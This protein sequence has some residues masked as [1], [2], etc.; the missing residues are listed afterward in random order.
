MTAT[1]ETSTEGRLSAAS[2]LLVAAIAYSCFDQ[3]A[4]FASQFAVLVVLLGGAG[5]A[6]AL[7]PTRLDRVPRGVLL[8]FL[9]LAVATLAS[10]SRAGDLAGALPTLALI[11]GMVVAFAVAVSEPSEG[12]ETLALG[13]VLC[14]MIAAGTAWIGVA[15]HHEP[16]G[17]GVGGI[18][19]GASGLTY[20][21]ATGAL[22]AMGL[23]LAL[24]LLTVRP[25]L[26]V[27]AGCYLLAVGLLTTMSRAGA[28]A[29][30]VGLV[31]L[32]VKLGWGLLGRRLVAL[33]PGVLVAGAA[34]APG[35]AV[36]SATR[37]ELT[38]PGL[39]AGLGLSLVLISRPTLA[40]AVAVVALVVG[41][42]AL[43]DALD[44]ADNEQLSRRFSVG[45]P[46]RYDEW[47]AARGE[48][49]AS[50]LLGQGPGQ[51]EF[52]W[53]DDG[54]EQ[55][56]ARFAHN[57]YL[58]LLATHGL[59]GLAALAVLVVAVVRAGRARA[60]PPDWPRIGASA[61]LVVFVVHS[62]FDFLWHVP[63]LPVVAAVLL[64]V[65]LSPTGCDGRGVGERI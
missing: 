34:L 17:L 22:L 6:L 38:W 19:R 8:G 20:A 35:I 9:A 23:M 61:G 7:E 15:L 21:N 51:A 59:V 2:W 26:A 32:G 29:A 4:F 1:S 28:L 48:F 54:G 43:V 24:A 31:V 57:E 50:P 10:A 16:W 18:W 13:V 64:G 40:T 37:P 45:D 11:A 62:G 3:G 14:G 44:G 49:T 36:W 12:R 33:A 65:V 52:T 25:G 63:V 39:A 41:A 42:V 56:S 60:G 55:R 5:V 27:T 46:D 58:E 53:I 47:R 30:G